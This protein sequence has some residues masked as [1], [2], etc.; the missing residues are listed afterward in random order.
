MWGSVGEFAY[1][2]EKG[3][4]VRSERECQNGDMICGRL[5]IGSRHLAVKDGGFGLVTY[6]LAKVLPL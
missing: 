6:I 3:P 5:G 1:K 2:G 4:S